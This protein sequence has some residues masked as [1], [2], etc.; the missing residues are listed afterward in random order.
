MKLAYAAEKNRKGH[1]SSLF[2]L[3]GGGG[4]AFLQRFHVLAGGYGR[5]MQLATLKIRVARQVFALANLALAR[6]KG[7]A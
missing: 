3:V 2:V 1:K 4:N 6:S 7:V 5:K